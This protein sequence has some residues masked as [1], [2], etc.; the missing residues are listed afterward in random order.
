MAN[1]LVSG[2][3]TTKTDNCGTRAHTR[4]AGKL[5]SGKYTTKLCAQTK[6]GLQGEEVRRARDS[7]EANMRLQL[8][9]VTELRE[10]VKKHRNIRKRF[11]RCRFGA[12]PNDCK[13]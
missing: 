7:L 12:R 10:R 4:T 9:V 3:A 5:A 8:D 13:M 2:S 6:E 1:R 11:G